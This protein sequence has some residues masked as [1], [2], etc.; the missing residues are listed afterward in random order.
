MFIV[1]YWAIL[2]EK[3]QKKQESQFR[4]DLIDFINY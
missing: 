2:I 1:Y 4:S 3:V